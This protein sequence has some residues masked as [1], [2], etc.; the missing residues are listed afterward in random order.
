MWLLLSA[1]AHALLEMRCAHPREV[2]LLLVM[3]EE[4]QA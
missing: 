2:T 4:A 3:S 1:S